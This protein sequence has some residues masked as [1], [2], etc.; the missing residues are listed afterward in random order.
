[1]AVPVNKRTQGQLAVNVKTRELCVYTLRVTAN[2]KFFPQE[3]KA[4]VEQLRDAAISI[5]CL[6][7]EA[8][9]IVVGKDSDRKRRRINFQAQAADRCNTLCALIDIAKPL[10]HLSSKRVIY[11]TNLA[12]QARNMIRAWRENDI[13]RYSNIE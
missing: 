12:V 8:N 11:W 9:N 10:F 13:K 6:C 1:M 3:Q 7:W 2:E 5:H 4:F